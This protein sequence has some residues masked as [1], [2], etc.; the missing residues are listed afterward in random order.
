MKNLL[1]LPEAVRS[2]SAM[3]VQVDILAAVQNSPLN[4]L[5]ARRPGPFLW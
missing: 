1:T 5:C 2:L 3:L 4:E